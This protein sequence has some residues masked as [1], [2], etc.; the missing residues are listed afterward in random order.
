VCRECETNTRQPSPPLQP[1]YKTQKDNLS[2]THHRLEKNRQAIIHHGDEIT[3]D[4]SITIRTLLTD[5]FRIFTTPRPNPPTPFHRHTRQGI[6]PQITVY[7]DGSCINNGNYNTRSGAGVWFRENHPNNRALRVPGHDQSNQTGELA[8]IVIALQSTSHEV[9]LTIVTDSQYA[10]KSLTHSLSTFEDQA[11]TNVPNEKWLRLA[12][13]LLRKQAAP[14][15]FKWVK[16]HNGNRGNKGADEL[17]TLGANKVEIDDMDLTIPILAEP[18]GM[19]LS[20]LSQAST[21]KFLQSLTPTPDQR[22]S[23]LLL[24]C[25]REALKDLN[26]APPKDESIWRN[27]KHPDIKQ[28]IQSFLFRALHG[29]LRISEFWHRIPNFDHHATCINCRDTTESLK[30]ILLECPH[31]QSETIWSL[32]RSIWPESFGAWPAIYLGTILGCGSIRFPAQ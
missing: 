5:C 13:Y 1:E 24:D 32:A 12:A 3:F 26:N 16:G 14:T 31:G 18:S 10:I 30:H 25:T 9:D 28:P 23:E 11:W 7:T 20:S 17:A 19:R 27:L 15:H 22:R 6:P 8:A 2:L 21:Y 29:S 4:P